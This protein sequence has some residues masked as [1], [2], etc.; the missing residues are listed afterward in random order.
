MTRH[1]NPQKEILVLDPLDKARHLPRKPLPKIESEADAKLAVNLIVRAT[2]RMGR[3]S[4]GPVIHMNM[5]YLLHAILVGLLKDP[6]EKLGMPRVKELVRSDLSSLCDWLEAHPRT[7]EIAGLFVE[8][9]RSGARNADTILSELSM[10]ISA[11]ELGDLQ[12]A[13]LFD[14]L[15][16]EKLI[17]GPTLMILELRESDPET[18]GLIANRMVAEI[19]RF[20]SKRAEAFPGKVLPRPVSFIF[21]DFA[22]LVCGAP[23]LRPML[24]TLG[25]RN[26]SVAASIQSIAELKAIY[27]D[28]TELVLAG[29]GSK[30][31]VPKLDQSDAEWASKEA[32]QMTIRFKTSAGRRRQVGDVQKRAILTHD[33]IGRPPD[34]IA[35]FF[36]PNTPVFQGFPVSCYEDAE[37]SKRMNQFDGTEQKLQPS[38]QTIA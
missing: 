13:A 29:F 34:N 10:R 22:S 20:L 8:L 14:E 18:D 27:G 35:T 9:A 5:R 1:Y 17:S 36:M 21:E 38:N 19:F 12:G 26:I 4:D 6:N 31:F 37:I 33:E 23:D 32:G 7:I 28:D 15:D 3:D 2:D 24:N 16:I 25:A 30:F 11:W